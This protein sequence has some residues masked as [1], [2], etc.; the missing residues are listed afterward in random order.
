MGF[1]D[2]NQSKE[3]HRLI[4][5]THQPPETLDHISHNVT[6]LLCLVLY[7]AINQVSPPPTVTI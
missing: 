4:C 5:L 3:Y 7:K 1:P 2:I 6:S